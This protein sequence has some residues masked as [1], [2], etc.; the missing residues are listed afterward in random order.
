MILNA[1]IDKGSL[2]SGLRFISFSPSETYEQAL[3]R[4]ADRFGWVSVSGGSCLGSDVAN[5]TGSAGDD[6]EFKRTFV[7]AGG[8]A[9]S[10]AASPAHGSRSP[11]SSL[12]AS[13]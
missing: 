7:A 12:P 8:R 1:S 13:R 9:A 11:T 2:S 10:D 3:A 6:V 4:A 5:L